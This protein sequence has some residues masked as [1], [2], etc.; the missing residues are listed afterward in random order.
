MEP[1]EEEKWINAVLGSANGL[2]R[3][4]PS[5]FLFAKI[6]HR[7]AP[8]RPVYV[9]TRA[10]WLASVSFVVLIVVNWRVAMQ[11]VAPVRTTDAG[12]TS[13]VSDMQLYPVNNQP[14]SLWSAQNY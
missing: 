11:P 4:E 1:N 14:Y 7:L 5:P 9:S 8:A 10:V 6:R 2:Q 13:I 3:A 12:L